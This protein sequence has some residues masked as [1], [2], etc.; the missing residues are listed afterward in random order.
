MEPGQWYGMTVGY[1]PHLVCLQLLLD[2]L[3][4]RVDGL[5]FLL[6]LLYSTQTSN[7]GLVGPV[8]LVCLVLCLIQLHL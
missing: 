5:L 6:G 8:K 7:E 2:Y 1:V 3:H 4:L